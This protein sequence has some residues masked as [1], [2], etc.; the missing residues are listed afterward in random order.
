MNPPFHIVAIDGP[1]GVGK[2]TL[3]RQLAE[4][5]G[6]L[7]V[8]TGA[9]FRCLGLV[10]QQRGQQET[11]TV[12]QEIGASTQIHVEASRFFCNGEDV[13]AAIRTEEASMLASRISQFPEIREAMKEQQRRVVFSAQEH[14][15]PGAVLEGRDIGTVIFPEASFKFF[16]DADPE[17]RAQRRLE[18][19]QA[20]GETTTFEAVFQALQERDERDRNRTV[21]PL[22]QAEDA[23]LVDTTN[24][25]VEEALDFMRSHVTSAEKG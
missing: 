23:I 12:L 18:Q 9:M 25:T 1:T 2:S 22:R 24:R 17:V 16:V 15:D 3:A 20:K 21:A 5:L 7:Y 13:T 6:F 11:S 19:L 4:Q 14:G 10:W 8:D